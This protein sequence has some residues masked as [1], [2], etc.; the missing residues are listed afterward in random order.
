MKVEIYG[1]DNSVTLDTV[2]L[3]ASEVPAYVNLVKSHG[4]EDSDG[5]EYKF[6]NA[7][8]CEGGFVVYVEHA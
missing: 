6:N 4:F 3:P 8:V 5:E 7:K 2:E 1:C